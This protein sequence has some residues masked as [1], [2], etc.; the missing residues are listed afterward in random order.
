[1]FDFLNIAKKSS[2]P[3]KM[4]RAEILPIRGIKDQDSIFSLII[5][6]T[7]I[8]IILINRDISNQSDCSPRNNYGIGR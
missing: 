4:E 3:V 2:N 1:V 6:P 7:K 5:I 8:V